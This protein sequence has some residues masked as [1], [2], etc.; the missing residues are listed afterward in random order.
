MKKPLWTPSEDRI[1]NANM[2]RFIDFVNRKHGKTFKRYDELYQ[3][4]VNEISQFWA[5]AWEF[6]GIKASK[7]Y[8]RVVDNPRKMP[9][10]RWFEGA[11]LNFA[12]NLLRYRDDRVALTFK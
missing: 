11:R 1:R 4:S 2:T 3:W 6:L 12:Q 9:G 7:G 10:A 8:D 5:T